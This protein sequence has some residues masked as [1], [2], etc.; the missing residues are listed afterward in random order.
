M[1]HTPGP[2]TFE[3]PLEGGPNEHIIGWIKS[4][5]PFFELHAPGFI[6][7]KPVSELADNA[8]LMA[9]A[10]S[11]A[12]ALAWLVGLKDNRP[13]DYEEQKPLA[14]AAA[15]AALAQIGK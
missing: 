6:P 1:T 2:W 5:M 9:A 8:R 7:A 14:W 13:S 4:D 11:L 12:L 3:G 15:R 10:P